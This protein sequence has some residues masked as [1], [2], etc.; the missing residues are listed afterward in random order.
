MESKYAIVAVLIFLIASY[1]FSVVVGIFLSLLVLTVFF[2]SDEIQL[3]LVK[4]MKYRLW[5]QPR[6]LLKGEALEAFK[7]QLNEEIQY[8]LAKQDM[9]I[10]KQ[11]SRIKQL[12]KMLEQTAEINVYT[13]LAKQREDEIK[14]FVK[15]ASKLDW[16]KIRPEG[17]TVVTAHE[18]KPIGKLKN[19]Y[20][21]HN[22]V[23][24][25]VSNG[26]DVKYFGPKLQ[27][28]ALPRVW[29]DAIKSGV[30]PIYFDERGNFVPPV[31]FMVT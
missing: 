28:D 19:L 3:F 21:K 25:E 17:I 30:L 10:H 11:A 18:A 7:R 9:I 4:R 29:D 12:E 26:K 22:K 16:R 15:G 5:R 14:K 2:Y 24:I 8:R 27:D 6:T 1:L 23:L 13:A 31:R 20:Y